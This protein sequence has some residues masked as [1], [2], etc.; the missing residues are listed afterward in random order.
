MDSCEHGLVA[1]EAGDPVEGGVG[2]DS[3][4]SETVWKGGGIVV[5]EG[6][7]AGAL[8][9]ALAGGG[10]HGWR[11]VDAG[12]DRS[13]GGELFGED[14]VAAAE[15]HDLFAGL[16]CKESY[17]GGGEVG[18]EASVG[19]VGFGVPG[20]AGFRGG[21]GSIVHLPAEKCEDDKN[22]PRVR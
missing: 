4:E 9:I 5:L 13:G 22:F 2:E 15:V 19:C 3:V 16:R 18:D 21:H 8:E 20:L 12:D 6:Q 7:A 1:G 17:D 11:G 14:T 10:Q